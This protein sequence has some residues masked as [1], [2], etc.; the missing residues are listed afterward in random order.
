MLFNSNEI[1]TKHIYTNTNS[2]RGHENR[3]IISVTLTDIYFSNSCFNH[4]QLKRT[5]GSRLV[6]KKWN[7][8]VTVTKRRTLSFMEN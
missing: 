2:L 8:E 4:S 3:L 7:F 5:Q 6:N 1:I